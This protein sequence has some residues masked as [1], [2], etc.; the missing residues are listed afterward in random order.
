MAP[1]LIPPED[2][3]EPRDGSVFSGYWLADSVGVGG[4]MLVGQLDLVTAARARTAIRRAQHEN[5]ELTC[6]LG[7]VWFVDVCGLQVLVE[8]AALAE[9]T[10]ADLTPA[11]CPAPLARMLRLFK[12]H[13]GIEIQ[14]R[15]PFPATARPARPRPRGG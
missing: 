3:F 10:A 9:R 6:D 8:A 11:N 12:P 14:V 13:A 15:R 7:D 5:R 4:S 2:T 1:P